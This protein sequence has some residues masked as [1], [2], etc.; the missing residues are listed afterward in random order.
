MLSKTIATAILNCLVNQG[1]ST[2]AT[3]TTNTSISIPT[4][5][6]KLALFT[7]MPNA[8]G[9]GAKEVT[10]SGYAQKPLYGLGISGIAQFNTPAAWSE[11]EQMY[12]ISNTDEIQMHAILDDET[13]EET[14][15]GFGI[16]AG[17]QLH[18]WGKLLDAEGQETT[19]TLKAG[20]VPIFYTG[21]FQ[22]ML[23]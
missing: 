2:G 3:N 16:Y 8:N 9:T 21:R 4:T 23:G 5:T 12:T 1:S 20:S 14:V 10:L 7:Q 11:E 18:A 15:V 17:G 6:A 13:D 19:V 22:L